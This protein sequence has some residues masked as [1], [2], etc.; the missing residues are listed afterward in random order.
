MLIFLNH[1][2]TQMTNCRVVKNPSL[3]RHVFHLLLFNHQGL[4]AFICQMVFSGFSDVYILFFSTDSLAQRATFSEKNKTFE[5]FF[6]K[7]FS[8]PSI[9][10]HVKEFLNFSLSRSKRLINSCDVTNMIEM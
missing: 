10:S 2:Y 5:I 8:P 7:V 4:W 3:H 9:R 1:R 6:F